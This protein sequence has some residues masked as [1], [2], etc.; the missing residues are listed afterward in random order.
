MRVQ[1]EGCEEKARD[2]SGRNG[3]GREVKEGVQSGKGWMRMEGKG[4]EVK[5]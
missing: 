1:G 5:G 4:D 3:M 2:D